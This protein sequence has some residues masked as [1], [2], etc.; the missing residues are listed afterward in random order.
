M[1]RLLAV[2]PFGSRA[3]W[4]SRL[5]VV[6][7]LGSRA[8]S[9]SAQHLLVPMDDRQTNHLKAYGLIFNALKTGMKAEWF[10]NY[11][12][13]S[14]LLPDTPELRRRAALDGITFEPIDDGPA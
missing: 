13:G 5:L 8:V 4:Q 11:R 1:S 12:G 10:L 3:V 9:A 6:A 7:L 14:F 2:A